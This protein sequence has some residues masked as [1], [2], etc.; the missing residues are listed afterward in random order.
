MCD[1]FCVFVSKR[2]WQSHYFSLTASSADGKDTASVRHHLYKYTDGAT[3]WEL[4]RII[5]GYLNDCRDRAWRPCQVIKENK[6]TWEVFCLALGLDLQSMVE[7]SRAM[8]RATRVD[9]V[10]GMLCPNQKTRDVLTIST[11]GLLIVHT[12]STI[13]MHSSPIVRDWAR[14]SM[15]SWRG[16]LTKVL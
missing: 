2:S 1:G 4:Q 6:L 8:V 7:K 13:P 5:I 11:L 15:T 12:C 9:D 3:R 14:T 16:C 10:F